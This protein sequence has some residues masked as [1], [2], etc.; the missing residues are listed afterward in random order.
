MARFDVYTNPDTAERKL[1]PYL[2]DIQ[3]DH[4]KGLQ[5]RVVVPLWDSAMLPTP[6][7]ELNPEFEVV[8]RRVTMDS[9]ALG[10]IP[11]ALIKKAVG[12][13]ASQQMAIQNA[14]DTLFGGH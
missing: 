12:N 9:A 5:T 1:I 2:L 8:G 11:L 13:L 4:I 7:S 6:A 10:V 3:N 14:L